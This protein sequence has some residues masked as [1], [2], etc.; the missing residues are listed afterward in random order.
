MGS[1]LRSRA[2]AEDGKG[3]EERA[4]CSGVERGA[5]GALR[6]VKTDAGRVGGEAEK[7]SRVPCDVLGQDAIR[8]SPGCWEPHVHMAAYSSTWVCGP[9]ILSSHR[10]V[11]CTFK[12]CIPANMG[13]SLTS[14][15][16]NLFFLI[17]F[18]ISF[19]FKLGIIMGIRQYMQNA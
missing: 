14:L 6:S 1:F 13:A 8:Q 2:D 19:I 10:L 9:R 15:C 12:I 17:F 16:F 18:S 7:K 3:L 11:V 5:A 4:K